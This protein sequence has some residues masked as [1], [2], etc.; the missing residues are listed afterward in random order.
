MSDFVNFELAKKL[1]EKGFADKCLTYY[2]VKDNVGI[3][4]NTQYTDDISPCQRLQQTL[5]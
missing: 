1:K 3:L 2:D 4:F 5:W